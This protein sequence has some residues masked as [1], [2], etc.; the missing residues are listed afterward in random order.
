MA[1]PIED[2]LR[3]LLG[4]DAADEVGGCARGRDLHRYASGNASEEEVRSFEEHLATCPGCREDLAAIHHLAEAE[5]AGSVSWLERVRGLFSLRLLVPI[6]ATA[7]LALALVV[8]H[9]SGEREDAGRFQ[10]KSGFKL[11]VAVLRDGQGFVGTSGEEFAPG[12]SFNFFYTSPQPG[13]LV[14]LL[15][16]EKGGIARA[17][18]SEATERLPQGVEA[19]LAAGAV[20]DLEGTPC[21][22][23]VGFFSEEPLPQRELEAA[24]ARAIARRGADC[25][26]PPLEVEAA[27]DVFVVRSRR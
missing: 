8:W 13:Y 11:H 20:L 9:R 26:L 22:W 21:E 3:V 23:I 17:F 19:R 6:A 10:V 5:V 25:R 12:D 7:A 1:D 18:P 15:A 2:A 4:P 27:S 24:L 16:D 14:V